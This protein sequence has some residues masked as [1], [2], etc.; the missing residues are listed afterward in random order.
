MCLIF[1]SYNQHPDYRLIL[2]ANRDEFFSRPTRALDYW[3]D[4]PSVLAGRDLAGGGTWLGITRSLRFA[5]ITNFRDPLHIK[6]G[7]PSRGN[8]IRDFL[9][10]RTSLDAYI[11]QVEETGHQYNGFNLLLGEGNRLWYY[12]NHNAA[13]MDV[14]AGL[15]GLSNHL[16]NTPWPKVTSGKS[17]LRP[18]FEQPVIDIEAVFR[19]LE[20][21]TCPAADQLP[22]TGVGPEWEKILAPIFIHSAV[23]G[24]RCTSILT[25]KK[26]GEVLFA[27]RTFSADPETRPT[28]KKHTFFSAPE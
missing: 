19:V 10:R 9:C 17:R 3:E 1:F 15:H 16:L 8:L 22:D 2:A 23:Y 28:Q 27:E 12:S 13:S 6:P 7:A 11:R 4:N 14:P 18:L 26:T 21:R 25:I 24:T 20:D 5:A